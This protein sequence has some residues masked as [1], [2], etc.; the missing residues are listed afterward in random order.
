MENK[1]CCSS[2]D[3]QKF[4]KFFKAEFPDTVEAIYKTFKWNDE[5]TQK[6]KDYMKKEC[7]ECYEKMEECCGGECC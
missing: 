1:H 6:V 7:P 2:K 4:I 5:K 3:C